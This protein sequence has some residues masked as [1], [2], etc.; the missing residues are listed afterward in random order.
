MDSGE[1]EAQARKV[2]KQRHS[3]VER[4][5]F[6]KMSPE[7]NA[8]VL[9]GEVEFKR[10]YFFATVRTFEAQV[11]MNTGEVTSYE[12]ARPRNLEKQQEKKSS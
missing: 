5:F 2:I 9:Q 7:E 11:N 8:W 1:A 4:I 12:E 6:R 3:R 10:A